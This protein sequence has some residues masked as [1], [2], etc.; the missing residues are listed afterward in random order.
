MA[1]LL[2]LIIMFSLSNKNFCFET[3]TIKPNLKSV[4]VYLRGAELTH[5]AKV[6]LEKG[7]EELIFTELSQN[8]EPNSINISAKGD[9]V[10]L[11]INQ[12]TNYLKIPE[13]S[14]TINL[15]EDSLETLNKH[16]TSKQ[17]AI[18][19]LKAEIELLYANREI[20]KREKGVSLADIQVFSDYFRK[21]L[22]EIKNKISE[23]SLEVKDL[24]KNIERINKQL[25]ELNNSLSKPVNEVIV[26]VYSK[27]NQEVEFTISYL[28]KDA[29]WEPIYDI[30]VNKIDLPAYLNYKASVKQNSGIEWKDAEIILSTRNTFVSN[31]KP[32]LIPWF[33]DFE[34][35][36]FNKSIGISSQKIISSDQISTENETAES[37]TNYYETIQSQFSTEFIPTIK[38]SIP[39]DNKSYI[40]ELQNFT[41][42]TKYEYYSVPKLD[43]NAFLIAYLTNWNEYNLLPSNA[44]IFFENS[45]VGKTYVNPFTSKDTLTISLGR[46][47]NILV[48]KNIIKDF[49]KNKFLSN[50]IERTY[51]Y[52]IIVKNNKTIPINII[53]EDN[54]PISM[55][56]EIKV[57][58]IDY[59]DG[60]YYE[61]DGKIRWYIKLD[62]TKSTTKKLV[63]SVSHPKDKKV[64]NL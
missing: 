46:D 9:L 20:G 19:V 44:N 5:F 16:L 24:Q 17:N 12:R 10:L 55:N 35:M 50:D 31:E 47:Q 63:Y 15:L 39:S 56:E 59:S 29:S 8:I 51:A 52:E 40:I 32:E 53:V 37:L 14:K 28:I 33:I 23:I 22:T 43:N 27:T 1:K 26:S 38:Y 2:I 61:K 58:L 49:T 18:D 4:K 41:I 57:K 48:E 54:I 62:G 45:Y 36:L 60:I 30:R 13:K 25:N 42:P 7:N 21:R 64:S 34:K 3:K 6:K 11:S